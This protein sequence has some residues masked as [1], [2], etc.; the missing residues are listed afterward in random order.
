MYEC[1]LIAEKCYFIEILGDGEFVLIG[2]VT[3]KGQGNWALETLRLRG[4]C[5]QHSITKAFMRP[6]ASG[7]WQKR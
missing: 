5:L 7:R 1:L 6:W 4:V 3:L 2:Y